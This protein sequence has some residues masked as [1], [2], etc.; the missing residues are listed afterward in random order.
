MQSELLA[1]LSFILISTFTPGPNNVSSAAVAALHG[2]WATRRY[3]LGIT[4]GFLFVMGM[5]ALASAVVLRLLPGVETILRVVGAGYT[6]YLA[7]RILKASYSFDEGKARP[8]AFGNGFVLQLL[9]PKLMVYGLTLFSTYLAPITSE[10]LLVVGAVLL[11]GL[12]ALS[13]TAVWA[14]FGSAIK[15]YLRSPRAT[16]A[17]NIC[18]S[19]FLVLTALDLVV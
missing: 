13:A 15:R 3:L 12:V 1:A 17:L 18:L 10:P 16:L 11:L 9:N 6:L 7:Y 2:F 4:A 8:F 19:A 14:G 5:C